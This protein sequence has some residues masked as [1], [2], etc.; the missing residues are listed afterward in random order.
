MKTYIITEKDIDRL[1]ESFTNGGDS[2]WF[3]AR[4]DE[5]VCSLKEGEDTY[6]C[7]CLGEYLDY[8]CPCIR[9]C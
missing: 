6:F 4:V 5:W 7:E 1:T 3:E 9:R 8:Q 2:W